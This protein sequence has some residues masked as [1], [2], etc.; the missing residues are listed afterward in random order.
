[1]YNSQ[2][3]KEKPIHLVS[4]N[5]LGKLVLHIE[6]VQFLRELTAPIA[7]MSIAGPYRTGK[8]FLMNSLIS[9]DNAFTVGNTT[10]TTTNGLWIWSKP[11]LAYND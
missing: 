4:V 9:S 2:K 11:I 8:S 1:M 6:G 10:N 7:I 3:Y 5:S